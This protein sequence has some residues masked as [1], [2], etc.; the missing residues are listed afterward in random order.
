MEQSIKS[1]Y[2]GESDAMRD[3]E[4]FTLRPFSIFNSTT[5]RRRQ[6][7][8]IVAAARDGA[9]GKGGDMIWHL[10]E[11]LRHF[12]HV[13]MGH[14]VIMGRRTFE[15]LPKGALPGRRNIVVSRNPDFSA[16]D[17]E[18]ASSFE[19]AVALC[20]S[21][22][23]PFIIGGEQIYRQSFPFVTRLY[24]TR[25]EADCPEADTFFPEIDMNEWK[26]IEE[27]ELLGDEV[28][29]RFVTLDRVGS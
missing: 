27:S 9:I 21:S 6:L 18:V 14:P 19:D 11:D 20:E 16:P 17:V 8:S 24:L 4:D 1:L 3:K 23:I 22:E 12:K 5:A 15:S 25:I 10:R 28:K 13:T 7:F 26:V 29:F 2:P